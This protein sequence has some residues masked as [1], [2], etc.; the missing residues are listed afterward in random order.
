MDIGNLR[1]LADPYSVIDHPSDMFREMPIDVA[2]MVPMG[3]SMN[4]S[5]RE[6]TF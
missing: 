4:T 1:T 6:S 3:S 2:D 5:M